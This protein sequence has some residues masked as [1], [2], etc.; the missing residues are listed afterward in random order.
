M[1]GQPVLVVRPPPIAV[2]IAFLLFILSSGM[3][4]L[5]IWVT[6]LLI[7]AIALVGAWGGQLVSALVS[8][9][10]PEAPR[11]VPIRREQEDGE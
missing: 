10:G 8:L 2:F 11:A 7:P 3:L 5:S 6:D 4:V 9:L 1:Q